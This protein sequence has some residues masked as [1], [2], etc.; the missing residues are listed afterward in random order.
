MIISR[1]KYERDLHEAAE[2]AYNKAQEEF[3]QREEIRGLQSQISDL[4]ERVRKLEPV[5]EFVHP[6]NAVTACRF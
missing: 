6:E 5:P 2:K 1:R 3:W 4:K